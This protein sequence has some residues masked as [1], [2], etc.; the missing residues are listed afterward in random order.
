MHEPINKHKR[1]HNPLKDRETTLVG[2]TLSSHNLSTDR[3][4]EQIEPSKEAENLLASIYK[5][6]AFMG[7]NYFDVTSRDGGRSRDFRLRHRSLRKI[8]GDGLVFFLLK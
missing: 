8:C 7:V 6:R 5:F 2:Q 1:K 3:T 4:G